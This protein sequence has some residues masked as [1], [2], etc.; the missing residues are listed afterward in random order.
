MFREQIACF[1]LGFKVYAKIRRTISAAKTEKV[2]PELE[3]N[4]KAEEERDLKGVDKKLAKHKIIKPK[5]TKKP[6]HDEI[7]SEIDNV[8]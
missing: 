5:V 7:Q 8:D 1:D 3:E 2:K 4:Y 6:D